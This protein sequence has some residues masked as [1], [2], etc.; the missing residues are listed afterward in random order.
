MSLLQFLVRV[1]WSV[2]VAV[3]A[4]AVVLILYVFDIHPERKLAFAVLGV[5]SDPQKLETLQWAAVAIAAVFSAAIFNLIAWRN[6]NDREQLETPRLEQRDQPLKIV[7]EPVE[8][9]QNSPPYGQLEIF[10]TSQ[11]RGRPDPGAN[12]STRLSYARTEGRYAFMLYRVGVK[13]ASQD[14]INEVRLELTSMG[15]IKN[16]FLPTRMKVRLSSESS[17]I[18]DGQEEEF[19]DVVWVPVQH[20]NAGPDIDQLILCYANPEFAN[21]IPCKTCEFHFSARGRDITPSTA[22]FRLDVPE[23]GGAL[24]YQ[25]KDGKPVDESTKGK[26]KA[27]KIDEIYAEAVNVRNNAFTLRGLDHAT[28]TKMDDLQSKLL[29]EMRDIEPFK[30]INLN[31]INKY[32]EHDHPPCILQV[33]DRPRAM[34]FSEFLIRVMRILDDYR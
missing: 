31:T 21:R 18:L 13:N 23:N 14:T 2:A 5:I 3:V 33:S 16:A 27:R 9:G 6:E 22:D 24:F 28:R 12:D 25:V 10:T 26:L 20:Y 34:A 30:S 7:F 29:S 11:L 8:F 19:F 1:A 32:N 15:D 17:V 4:G